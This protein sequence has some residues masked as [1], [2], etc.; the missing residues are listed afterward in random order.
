MNCIL[1]GQG[2]KTFVKPYE[3]DGTKRLAS[4]GGGCQLYIFMRFFVQKY[5]TF[6]I[7]IFPKVLTP[8][9]NPSNIYIEEI[10]LY[11]GHKSSLKLFAI[12]RYFIGTIGLSLS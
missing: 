4:W 3:E 2:K 5:Q 1:S 11:L 7:R 8:L 10:Y 12:Y 6:H 9:A